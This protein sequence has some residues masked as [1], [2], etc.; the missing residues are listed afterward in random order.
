[1][2][3]ILEFRFILS[4]ILVFLDGQYDSASFGGGGESHG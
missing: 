2:L 4:W 1:M 3:R